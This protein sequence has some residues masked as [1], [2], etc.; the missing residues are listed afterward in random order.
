MVFHLAETFLHRVADNRL[1]QGFRQQRVRLPDPG[2][3]HDPHGLHIDHEENAIIVHGCQQMAVGMSGDRL[4]VKQ[5]VRKN[6][7]L[8]S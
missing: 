3:I 4:E 8:Q 7:V 1:L 6:R 2:L 5:F